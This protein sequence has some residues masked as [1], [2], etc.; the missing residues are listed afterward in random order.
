MKKLKTN[1]VLM[2][3]VA[4]YLLVPLVLTLIYSL[5]SEWTSLLPTGFTFKFYIEVLSDT[6]FWQSL[7]RSVLMSVIPP[8][9]TAGMLLLVMYVV[10]VYFP[11]LD[12]YV[13]ILCTIP[14]AI[15]GVIL[16]ISVLS[17][18]S[19]APGIFSNRILL[20]IS[21]YCVV[22]LPYMYQGIKNSLVGVDAKRII[23]A[24]QMLGSSKFMAF[25]R[26]VVPCIAPSVIISSLIAVAI[27]FGDFVIVNTIAGNY[28]Q[29]AQVYLYR[30]M[31]SSGQ[32]T[33]AI[34]VIV[35]TV[36]LLISMFSYKRQKKEKN[37]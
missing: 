30:K 20:L 24:A 36:T 13:N 3:I 8:M 4:I 33:S 16:P 6:L 28:Y 7:A 35:Y 27:V 25:F 17:L 34:I 37:S 32:V 15:Q 11:K 14:Y 29:T 26:I 1:N 9:L 2:I 21:T 22:I 23:E 10:V 31:S 18:Y 19:G 12:R 5:F